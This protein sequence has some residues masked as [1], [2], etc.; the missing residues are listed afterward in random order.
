M[1]SRLIGGGHSSPARLRKGS[2]CVAT[3]RSGRTLV[4]CKSGEPNER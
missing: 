3:R 4:I 1:P 2:A